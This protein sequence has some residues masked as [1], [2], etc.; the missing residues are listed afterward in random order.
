VIACV[1]FLLW[2]CVVELGGYSISYGLLTMGSLDREQRAGRQT[3][4]VL[5]TVVAIPIF[6]ALYLTSLSG[7]F[8]LDLEVGQLTVRYILP[9]RSMVLPI[10]EVMNVQEEPAYKGR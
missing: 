1:L 2:S 4:I 7:F 6:F 5:G 3:S 9:E 10:S 8:Q